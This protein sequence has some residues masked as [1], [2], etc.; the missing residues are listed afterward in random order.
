MAR[1]VT[2]VSVWFNSEGASPSAVIKKLV[3]LGFIPVRGAYDFI[4]KHESPEDMTESELGT[5]I[6][7]IS[8][9][10]HKTLA[11]FKVLYTLDTH[12]L[13]DEADYVPL[14]DIDAELEATRKEIQ[15]LERETSELD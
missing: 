11:G 3:S 13:D 6:I 9:A 7:E 12:T 4:Y 15:E 14:E 8:N 5:A 2:R 10:L 1:Y